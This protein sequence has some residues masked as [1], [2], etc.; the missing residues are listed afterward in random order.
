MLLGCGSVLG[1]R[2]CDPILGTL[3][4]TDGLGAT[5]VDGKTPVSGNHVNDA[6]PPSENDYCIGLLIE[7]GDFTYVTSG[8]LDGAS[9][10]SQLPV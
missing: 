2:C 3:Q 5:L 9:T 4:A 10:L 6:L 1:T 7:F 8:D